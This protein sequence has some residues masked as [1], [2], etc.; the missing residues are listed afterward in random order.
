MLPSI[1]QSLVSIAP[2]G[3]G[4]AAARQAVAAATGVA[5]NSGAVAKD[6][7]A[8]A[9]TLATAAAKAG[10]LPA[11]PKAAKPKSSAA[12]YASSASTAKTATK[13]SASKTTAKKP[14]PLAF[15]DDTKLSVEDKLMRLLSYLN[16]KWDKDIQ[17]KMKEMKALAGGEKA[18]SSSSSSTSS[19]SKSKGGI[20][21]SIT[22]SITSSL[23][24]VAKVVGVAKQFFP[25]VG[26]ALDV[27]GSATT[28]SLLSKL[29]GPVLAA[30]ASAVGLPELAP[31]ALKLGPELADVAAGAVAS[32]AGPAVTAPASSGSS[33]GGTAAPSGATD[34][35]GLSSDREAQLRLMEIQRVFDQQRE[36]FSLVSN[37]LRSGHESR[38]AVIQNVR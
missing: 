1:P 31:L 7:V 37:I 3:P 32:L 15:L 33:S 34:G 13:A 27:V 14:G 20:L 24:S 10:L 16:D 18:P 21:G 2:D 9:D 26:I 12:G 23:G 36:M 5:R 35:A 8:V 6:V 25:S 17:K 11:A 29:G 22:S 4:A 30:A 38:L 19:S 28:R